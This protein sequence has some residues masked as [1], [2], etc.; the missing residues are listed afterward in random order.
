MNPLVSIIVPAFNRASLITE[1]LES[2]RTQTYSP[3][4]LIVVDDGSTDG[5]R[6]VVT[7]WIETSRQPFVQ[8]FPLP[9]NVGK[10]SAVNYALDRLS[11]EFVMVVDSDDLLLPDGVAAEVNYL[12]AHP[13]V[14]MVSARPYKL[15]GDKKTTEPFDVYKDSDTFDDLVARHGDSLING[16]TIISS[17]VMMRR[18][19]VKRIGPLNVKL[20][21]THDWE[22]WIRV[23]R[24]FKIAYFAQAVI[25]Y[26]TNVA[27]ASS[28]KRFGTFEE[29]CTLLLSAQNEYDR[30]TLSKSILRQT[31][32][33]SGL[34]YHDPNYK[35]ML[36]IMM[37]GAFSSLKALLHVRKR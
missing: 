14:G 3:I 35:E 33:H 5:T 30:I 8:F 22:Y 36:K 31:K 19:V 37:F 17:T 15:V 2:I 11:G 10:S 24:H 23:S 6:H 28:M 7:K 4:E 27:G 13:D 16:N 32:D 12:L 9:Q 20:R 29:I 18:D 25:Y 1:T 34:A 21:Y 26:R